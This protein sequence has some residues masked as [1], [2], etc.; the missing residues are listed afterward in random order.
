MIKSRYDKIC[1][2]DFVMQERVKVEVSQSNEKLALLMPKFVLDRINY[3]EMSSS[4][5]LIRKLPC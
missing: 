3:Y 4:L 2:L 5:W 1:K